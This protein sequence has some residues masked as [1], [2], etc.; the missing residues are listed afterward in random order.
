MMTEKKV[1]VRPEQAA[2]LIELQQ[3]VATAKDRLTVGIQAALVGGFDGPIMVDSIAPDGTVTVK[4]H[5]P[6]P[7]PEEEHA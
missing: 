5:V 2:Y 7:V 4:M 1:K 6:D 3:A